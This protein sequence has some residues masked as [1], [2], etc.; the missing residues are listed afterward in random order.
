[1]LDLCNGRQR[2]RFSAELTLSAT[3]NTMTRVK[4]PGWV[5]SVIL[6]PRTNAA[7]LVENGGWKL[8]VEQKTKDGY[9]PSVTNL[10]I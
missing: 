2:A 8:R 3:I 4:L 5:G 9:T 6:T 7:Y 1:M 10:N